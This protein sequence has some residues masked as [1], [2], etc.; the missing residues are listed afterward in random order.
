MPVPVPPPPALEPPAEFHSG[1]PA[2]ERIPTLVH[3]L[4]FVAL[5]FFCFL[6]A[7]GLVLTLFHSRS[8]LRNVQNQP[9][10]LT[11]NAL[12]YILAIGSSV[13]V[14]PAL[15]KRSFSAGVRW[16]GS[17]ASPLWLLAGLTLGYLAQGV[18]SRLTLPRHVPVDDLFRNRSTVWF[19]VVF[20]TLVAPVFEEI[21]FRGFLLPALANLIDWLR[22]PRG[23]TAEERTASLV[24]L[25]VWSGSRNNSRPAQIASSILTSVAFALIHAPQL[26]Y[27]W[28]AVSLLAAVSLALCW[29]RLRTGSVA[30][31]TMVHSAYNFSVFLSLFIVTGGFQHLERAT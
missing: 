1:E 5:T 24:A 2:S 29:I 21:L 3:T 13:L 31:S 28:A 12:A 18:E 6:L 11:A 30:A 9:L 16:N 25:E 20:G 19:L 27:T 26:G 10:Q 22:L 7:E 23:R 8:L 4:L 14:F 15:W 17:S